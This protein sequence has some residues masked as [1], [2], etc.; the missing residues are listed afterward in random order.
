MVNWDFGITMERLVLGSDFYH[1]FLFVSYNLQS[2][3][4]TLSFYNVNICLIY[5][6]AM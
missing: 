1:F 5:K 6:G 4:L 3:N 2:Y